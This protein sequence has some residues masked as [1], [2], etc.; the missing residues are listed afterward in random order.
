[1]TD[2][3]SRLDEWFGQIMRAL[4][5]SER[6]RAALKLGQA[7]RRS[8][9]ARIA[10]NLEPDGSPMER[11]KARYD[12]HRRLRAAAGGKMFKGLRFAKK[13]RIDIADDSVTLR[14][15]SNVGAR[16]GAINQFGETATV[17]RLRNG[18]SIRT[19]YPERRL[20]GFSEGDERLAVDVAASFVK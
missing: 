8:N 17:G 5:P 11:K 20:L 10:A 3:L 13:W 16:V 4:S 15:A 14:P 7:L 9:L 1:M 18:R 12:E 19:K 6:R 2:D